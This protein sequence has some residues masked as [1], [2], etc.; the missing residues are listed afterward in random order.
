MIGSYGKGPVNALRKKQ[1]AILLETGTNE[2]E[3]LEFIIAGHRF[4]INVAKVRE[5]IQHQSVQKM[6]RSQPY[7]E[8]VFKPRDEV[9]TV[10]D[11]AGYLGL[12]PSD[13]IERDIFI[14]ASFNQMKVAFHVHRVESIHRISWEAIEKPNA[15]IFGGSEGVITGIAK[16]EDRMIS[17]VDFEKIMYDISPDTS[18]A[19]H[20]ERI[21]KNG[22]RG[23]STHPILIAEDSMV[24][25]KMILEALLKAGYLNVIVTDNGREAWERLEGLKQKPGSIEEHVSCVITDIEMPQM[26]GHHLTRRIKEDEVLSKIPVIIF[27]SLITDDM[28]HKGEEVGA[29]AQLSKPDINQLVDIIDQL[30]P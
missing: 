19:A 4:G 21:D 7:V 26:D 12:P 13:D 27:S 23:T 20:A 11:L 5:L 18:I 24:L 10:I 16:L 9:F 28:R 3:V 14:V 30:I 8:G 22:E 29:D 6:P 17:I 15:S 1:N 25:R 2:L